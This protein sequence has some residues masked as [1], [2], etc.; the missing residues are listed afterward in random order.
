MS[1]GTEIQDPAALSRAG[2]GARE[3]AWQTQT[4]GAHPVDETHSAARDFGSGN[5]DGG[6]NGALTGAA[7][8]WSAQVSAL[9]ADCGKFAEQ[10][11]STAMQ[12]QRVE[13]DI[14]QTFRSM[15]N[16]FG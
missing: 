6:L 3:I 2:S 8:T 10:C 16:G 14:S 12:Y 1:A 5:W 9:A 4:T 13:T 7:E 15:A 11:D